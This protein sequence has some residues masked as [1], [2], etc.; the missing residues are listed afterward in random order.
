MRATLE[1]NLP[2]DKN[3]HT[4]AVNGGLYWQTLWDLDMHCRA[5]L[6]CG[7]TES[8]DDAYE[9]VRQF[10]HDSVNMDEID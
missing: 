6:K 1:F 3:E 2:E 7:P 4:M 5:K 10:I 9:S 8:A